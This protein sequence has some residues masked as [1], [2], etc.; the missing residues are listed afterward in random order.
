MNSSKSSLI[1][2]HAGIEKGS[3]FVTLKS[4][5]KSKKPPISRSSQVKKRQGLESSSQPD[6]VRNLKFPT[7]GLGIYKKNQ[8]SQ[9]LFEEM[10]K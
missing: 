8:I 2:A 10:Q 6:L 3:K 1:I 4:T 5:L 9:N 7:L